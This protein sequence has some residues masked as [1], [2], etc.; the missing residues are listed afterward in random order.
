MSQIGDNIKKL[1]KAKGWSQ[2][3]LANKI[4]DENGKAIS[5]VTITRYEN[6]RDPSIETLQ[7]IADA[8]GYGLNYLLGKSL[9]FAPPT[10]EAKLR[11]ANQ[12][13]V[14]L[15][16][17]VISNFERHDQE[18]VYELIILYSIFGD[19]DKKYLFPML[20]NY[21]NLK[22][23]DK[24]EAVKLL[25]DFY[26]LNDEGKFEALKR[27]NELLQLDKYKKEDYSM[28]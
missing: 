9:Y 17:E 22:S 3:D 14:K 5:R 6:G 7:K 21:S 4:L 16:G 25:E 2:E 28:G 10:E 24:K 8:L 1:R 11:I 20:E 12:D 19:L 27:V 13:I 26:Y 23:D 18:I 15:C